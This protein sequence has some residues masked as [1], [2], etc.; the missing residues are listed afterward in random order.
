MEEVAVDEKMGEAPKGGT[1]KK[2]VTQREGP[3]KRK[4][5]M[6]NNPWQESSKKLRVKEQRERKKERKW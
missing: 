4:D 2:G 6:E 1:Q 3:K 5:Q